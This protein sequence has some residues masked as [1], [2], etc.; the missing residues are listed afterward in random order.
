[1]TIGNKM[2]VKLFDNT[3]V[4]YKPGIIV[5][6]PNEGLCSFVEDKKIKEWYANSAWVP[7]PGYD[8]N[9]SRN[10]ELRNIET[11]IVLLELQKDK[12]NEL[13]FTTQFSVF[14]SQ[15]TILNSRKVSLETL[16]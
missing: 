8:F 2:D 9:Q 3:I 13:S 12:A 6:G 5:E 10:D 4:N 14:A 1:M 7:N 15:L 16:T 11:Q